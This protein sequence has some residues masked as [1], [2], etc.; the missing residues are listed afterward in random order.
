[1]WYGGFFMTQDIRRNVDLVKASVEHLV[2]VTFGK[3]SSPNYHLAVNVS[4]GVALYEELTIGKKIVHCVV[5]GKTKEDAG[6]ALAVLNYISGWKTAQ[7][8]TGGKYN[9][10]TWEVIGVLECYMKAC[11]C[12]DYSAHCHNVIDDPFSEHKDGKTYSPNMTWQDVEARIKPRPKQKVVVD[13][14]VFPCVYAFREMHS[15][16]KDHP[17]KLIDQIQAVAVNVGCDWCPLFDPSSFKKVG[18][19]EKLVDFFE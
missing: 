4:I 7:V 10:S 8:F 14:Y 12:K 15:L 16:Q 19:K 9:N 17:A 3:T 18:A 1:M 13:R 11:S 5:F 2:A 6:R